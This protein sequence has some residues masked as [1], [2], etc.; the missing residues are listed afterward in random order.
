[1]SCGVY[2]PTE[3]LCHL[4]MFQYLFFVVTAAGQTEAG[5]KHS[6]E[7]AGARCDTVR[8]KLPLISVICCLLIKR[9]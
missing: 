1:M 8:K 5:I 2:W 4:T 9:E 3:N 7:V 6:L